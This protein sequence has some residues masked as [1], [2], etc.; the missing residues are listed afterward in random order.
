M[1][2]TEAHIAHLI[3][4]YHE[5]SLSP[6]E[7]MEL[8]A[9]V[10]E[11]PDL[12]MDLEAQPSL[13]PTPFQIDSTPFSHPLLEDLAIYKAEEGHPLEKLAIGALEGQLSKHEQ[14]MAQAYTQDAHYQKIEKELAY[15]RLLPDE[16]IRHPQLNS[17]LK[18]A[19][20]RQLQWRS[21]ALVGSAAAAVLLAVFLVGQSTSEGNDIP[22]KS[23]QQA[24][25]ARDKKSTQTQSISIQHSPVE[26]L[27]IHQVAIHPHVVDEPPRDCILPFPYE[28]AEL[29]I[30]VAQV[31]TTN[32]STIAPD[33]VSPSSAVAQVP[34]SSQGSVFEKAPVTMKAFLLQKTNERI[35]GTAAPSTDLKFETL[36]RYASESVGIPVRY[37]VEEAQNRDKLVFQLGPI[38]IEKTRTKK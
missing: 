38:T 19:P 1:K 11:N 15:T 21:Y 9:L 31:E 23:S 16:N 13:L 7:K 24:R 14:K 35:F 37:E 26:P 28:A 27:H 30:Q 12:A 36:A 32:S 5:G 29:G 33:Q 22:T 4:T 3:L 25:V 10:L 20:V 2:Y 6:A 17:L 34:V 8:E 18:S